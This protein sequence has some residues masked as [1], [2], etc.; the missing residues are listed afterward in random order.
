MARRAARRR[1]TSGKSSS[2]TIKRLDSPDFVAATAASA[3]FPLS[4]LVLEVSERRLVGDP[5]SSL[6][7][8]TR[9]K[10]K[11]IGLS[12]DDFGTGHASLAQL[13]DFQYDEIKIDCSF[14]H[15]ARTDALLDGIVQA[16]LLLAKQLKMTTVAEGVE[17]VDDWRHM[18]QLQC[19]RAQGYFIGRPMSVEELPRWQ[20]EWEGRLAGL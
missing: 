10:L 2:S 18:R 16:S 13:R 8:L 9:L 20:G 6:E 11:R 5:L 1:V 17:T 15:G 7:I 3:G 4:R 14:V 19:E 12:I